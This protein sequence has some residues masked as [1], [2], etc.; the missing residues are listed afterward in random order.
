LKGPSRFRQT[1]DCQCS[2]S[3]VAGI[4]AVW[5]T[6]FISAQSTSG[7][8]T[9]GWLFLGWLFLGW[10]F[11]GWLTFSSHSLRCKSR[12][13]SAVEG[14]QLTSAMRHATLEDRQRLDRA[15]RDDLVELPS[16]IA[17]IKRGAKKAFV[18][19]TQR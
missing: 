17:A 16:E 8:E 6:Q 2:D 7:A 9:V 15:V 5:E 12:P 11:L 18:E 10:L 3:T 14:E 19:L 1:S 4:N 13:C